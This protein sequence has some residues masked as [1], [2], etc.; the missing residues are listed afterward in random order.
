[1]Q[2]GR[3]GVRLN[4]CSLDAG[5]WYFLSTS[6]WSHYCILQCY[7]KF[8][9]NFQKLPCFDPIYRPSIHSFKNI[10]LNAYNTCSRRKNGRLGTYRHRIVSRQKQ[11][12]VVIKPNLN[13]QVS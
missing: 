8:D 12:T 10:L 13:R 11:L 2:C 6:V 5:N 9:L 3:F 4:V 1:G 7:Y